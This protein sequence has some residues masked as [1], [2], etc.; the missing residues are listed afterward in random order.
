[1]RRVV[2]SVLFP[3][4][5]LLLGVSDAHA[6]TCQRRSPENACGPCRFEVH[7][8]GSDDTT[9]CR[10]K[11]PTDCADGPVTQAR[12]TAT[13]CELTGEQSQRTDV[14]RPTVQDMLTVLDAA[15][16]HAAKEIRARKGYS[17]P[18]P[19][20]AQ[21]RASVVACASRLSSPLVKSCVTAN[22]DSQ[23]Y[24]FEFH[25]ITDGSRSWLGMLDYDT[26]VAECYPT[27]I[28]ETSGPNPRRYLREPCLWA[29]ASPCSP[30][31]FRTAGKKLSSRLRRDWAQLG[32][33]VPWP[34]SVS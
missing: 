29:D 12:W 6:G 21:R 28:Y 14:R 2:A 32:A 18:S 20:Y 33:E 26:G 10:S 31:Y 5:L 34:Y 23:G 8:G 25:S 16:H 27:A 30:E 19:S 9:Y 17:G 22:D 24:C 4:V 13:T 7:C 11:K 15:N 3:A 1:M